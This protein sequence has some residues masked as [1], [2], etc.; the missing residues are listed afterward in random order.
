MRS[1]SAVYR[2]LCVGTRRAADQHRSSGFRHSGTGVP[3]RLLARIGRPSGRGAPGPDLSAALSVAERFGVRGEG[4]YYPSEVR[5]AAVGSLATPNPGDVSDHQLD[6]VP[7]CCG[8]FSSFWSWSR[9]R[10]SSSADYEAAAAVSEPGGRSAAGNGRCRLLCRRASCLSGCDLERSVGTSRRSK[11]LTGRTPPH[12]G[13]TAVVAC[14]PRR[15]YV[16]SCP[17]GPA[18]AGHHHVRGALP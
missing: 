7:S 13:R 18:R 8:R 2:R 16:V 14:W 1:R 9:S 10:S 12:G 17:L 15:D 5:Q 11:L 3:V 4:T 6:G